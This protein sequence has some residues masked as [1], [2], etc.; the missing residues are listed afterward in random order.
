MAYE[1]AHDLGV[2]SGVKLLTKLNVI[3]SVIDVS[4][5]RANFDFALELARLAAKN[6]LSD[7]YSKVRYRCVG[8]A[9]SVR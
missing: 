1:W 3:E 9:Y 8:M 4:C 6:K 7:V 5:E 2:N